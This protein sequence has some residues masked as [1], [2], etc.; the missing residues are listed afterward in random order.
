MSQL[1]EELNYDGRHHV[2]IAYILW[3]FGFLGCHRFYLG[4][5]ISGTIYF[6]TFGLLG[7]GW[8]IDLF[9][10]PSMVRETKFE[11]FP[12]KVDYSVSWIC[13]SFFGIFGIHRLYMGKIITGI[14][15]FLTGGLFAFGYIYDL[16]TLNEQIDD[17]NKGA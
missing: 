12:G 3:L 7:V 11:Y 4:R 15:Y 13:L 6:F 9:L 10:I 14:L 2:I 16:W 5:P 17:I 8:I 1:S